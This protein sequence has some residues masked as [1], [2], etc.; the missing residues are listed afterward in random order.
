MEKLEQETIN[1]IVKE[2]CDEVNKSGMQYICRLRTCNADV[3]ATDNYYVLRSYRTLVA[4]IDADGNVY[5]FLRLVYG[6]TSA[7]AQHISKFWHDFGGRKFYTWRA[8]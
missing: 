1:A 3:W 2:V 5:D 7:S 6:Y 8:V 4:A